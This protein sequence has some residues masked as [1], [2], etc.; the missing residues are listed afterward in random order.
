M[1]IRI[2]PYEVEV[3]ETNP[4]EN[5]RLN[6]EK[7]IR[8]LTQLTSSIEGPCVLAIDAPWGTGK[9]TFLKMWTQYL[10]NE[11]FPVVQFNAW[12]TD[13]SNDPFLALSAELTNGLHEYKDEKQKLEKPIEEL[14]RMAENVVLLTF[15]TFIKHSTNNLIDLQQLLKK[16]GLS[17]YEKYEKDKDTFIKFKE[18]LETVADTLAESNKSH[19]LFVVIDELDRCRPSYA[20]ELLEVAKHFFTVDKI[21]FILTVDRTQL[22]QS[23]KVLYGENFDSEGYLR[24]FFDIDFRLPD[25]DRE[26]FIRARLKDIKI[27][28]YFE[29]EKDLKAE[30]SYETA[31]KI[32]L[33]FF[34]FPK[35]SL[36][37]IAQALHRL[38]LV[39]ASL[40]SNQ[41]AFL[42]VAIVVLV[43][44]TVSPDLYHKFNRRE[45]TDK[46]VV[47]SFFEQWNM[48]RLISNHERI[49]FE[50][51]II[52]GALENNMHQNLLM[53]FNETIMLSFNE[54]MLFNKINS[55]LLKHYKEIET[56]KPYNFPNLLY[57]ERAKDVI[58]YVE[59]NLSTHR[60]RHMWRNSVER[61]ELATPSLVND[62]T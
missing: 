30:Y 54:T 25:P 17:Q 16:D 21:I 61:L 45:I 5:D 35:I 60:D 37:N 52:L 29:C 23:I 51:T 19:P 8:I 55:P 12:E 6:R 13:F 46:E 47:K 26:D 14:K 56:E 4:F 49:I 40:Q 9:T 53:P 1:R 20:I 44:R 33:T 28:N 27:A 41:R 34:S 50:S 39:L 59:R 42:H 3:P 18:A 22:A 15:S 2:Q 38:G 11:N 24:R 43:L 31:E 57:K 32:L 48:D 10:R 58:A 36:R 62:Q 7:H